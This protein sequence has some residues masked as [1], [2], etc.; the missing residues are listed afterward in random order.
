MGYGIMADA[1][2]VLHFLWILFMLIGFFMTLWAV[3]IRFTF[4]R[5]NR[6]LDRWVFR[7][8]H[9]AGILFVALLAVLDKYCPLTIWE[10]QLRLKYDPDYLYPGSFIARHIEQLVYP[11][12][13]PLAI[14]IPTIF[15]AVFTLA[16]FVIC[17]P[18]KIKFFLK[19]LLQSKSG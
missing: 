16:A 17:P 5:R 2:L 18:E 12:V 19:A 10:Y 9:L 8:I 4:R 15:I 11:S 3:I 1:L 13:H 6:F 7:V 14:L